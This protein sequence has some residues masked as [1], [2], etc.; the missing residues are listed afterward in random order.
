MVYGW[1]K[2]TKNTQ[3]GKEH[4]SANGVGKVI[5]SHAKG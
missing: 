5:Y 1:Y 2:D 3:W 4:P